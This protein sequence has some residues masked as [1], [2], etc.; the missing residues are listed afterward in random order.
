MH[1][2]FSSIT[3]SF[4]RLKVVQKWF[5]SGSE[6]VHSPNYDDTIALNMKFKQGIDLH[7]VLA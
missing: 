1:T 4:A 6:V 5:E 2:L 7:C 3:E